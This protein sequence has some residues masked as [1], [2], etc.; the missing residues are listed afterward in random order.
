MKAAQ[1]LEWLLLWQLREEN[2][3]MQSESQSE[4]TYL[5]SS[6]ATVPADPIPTDPIPVDRAL[7]EGER[8]REAKA[9]VCR[10]GAEQVNLCCGTSPR[11]ERTFVHMNYSGLEELWGSWWDRG[12]Q[13]APALLPAPCSPKGSALF[14]GAWEYLV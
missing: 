14:Y 8:L 5:R 11:P 4:G 12:L 10:V 7:G 1:M 3:A 13:A 6:A 2:M 9:S